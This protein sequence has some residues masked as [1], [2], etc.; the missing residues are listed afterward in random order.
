[1]Q[2]VAQYQIQP[3]FPRPLLVE[4]K[5]SAAELFVGVSAAWRKLLVQAQMA[6]PYVRLA[7]VEGENG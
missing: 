5:S 1:M 2:S 7:A 6:A 4:T 3:S